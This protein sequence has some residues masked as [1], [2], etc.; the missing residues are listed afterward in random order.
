[1]NSK[2]SVIVPVYNRE[3]YIEK[4]IESLEGQTYKNIEIIMINDGSTDNSKSVCDKISKKYQNIKVIHTKNRGV[5]EARNKGLNMST[6][7]YILFVDPDD[8]IDKNMCEY[9]HKGYIENTDSLPICGINL[10]DENNI[11][12]KKLDFDEIS[13]DEKFYLNKNRFMELFKIDL[14]NSPCNK[15]FRKD[16][17]DLNNIKFEKGLSLG[18]DMFFM[19]SYIKYINEFSVI[20]KCLYNYLRCGNETLS[21]KSY[22]NMYEIQSG[23][24]NKLVENMEEMTVSNEDVKEIQIVYY[25]IVWRSIR[26]LMRKNE[27]MNLSFKICEFFKIITDRKTVDLSIENRK[28]TVYLKN[29]KSIIWYVKNELLKKI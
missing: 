27:E 1:M 13:S 3:K 7:E 23:I 14:L 6:G 4:C 20:N 24:F 12:N 5:S 26:N 15:L 19:M 17:I 9:M 28:E 22:K 16:I 10:V 18:E 2:I 29:Y 11:V 21:V 25:M 8:T